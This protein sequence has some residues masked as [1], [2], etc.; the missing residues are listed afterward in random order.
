MVILLLFVF[1]CYIN[2]CIA[3]LYQPQDILYIWHSELGYSFPNQQRGKVQQHPYKKEIVQC[4]CYVLPDSIV[5]IVLCK[6]LLVPKLQ[7]DK[8]GFTL[9]HAYFYL[10]G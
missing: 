4:N 1:S 5:G 3:I 9:S 6:F 8:Q 7:N 10:C 2:I